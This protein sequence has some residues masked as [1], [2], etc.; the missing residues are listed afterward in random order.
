M[1]TIDDAGAAVKTLQEY[2]AEVQAR[3][4]TIDE[5]WNIEPESPDGQ[6]IAIWTEL[7]AN[8]DEAVLRAYASVDPDTAVGQQLDRIARI[9]GLSRQEGTFSTATVTFTGVN[10]TVIPPGTEVRNTETETIWETDENVTIDGGTAAVGV[11]ATERGLKSAAIGDLSE[12]PSP[13]AGVDNVT[14]DSAASL[15]RDSESDALLRVRRFKSVAA[16]GQNQA[17][18]LFGAVANAEGVKSAAVYENVTATTDSNGLGPHSVAVFAEGGEIADIQAAIAKR[19]NPGTG[20]NATAGFGALEVTSE[21]ETPGGSPLSVT[22]F[23]PTLVP[24]YVDV[25]ITGSLEAFQEQNIKQA[26]VDYADASLFD[27]SREGFD[28]TGFEIGELVPAGKLYTPVNKEL[29]ASGYI[30]DLKIGTTSESVNAL[31]VPV[32]FDAL[33]VFDVDRITVITV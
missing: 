17:D 5:G 2:L 21:V 32:D 9:S 8:L 15:G 31:T 28:D 22:F 23:R 12:L 6:A 7:L 19:K 24:V 33:A 4:R 3:D 27:G 18:S 14:N 26:I 25:E 11:T 16:P 29:A 30:S 10:G 13:I 20:L 1:A